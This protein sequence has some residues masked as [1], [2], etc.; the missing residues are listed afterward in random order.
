VCGADARKLGAVAVEADARLALEAL[1]PR[2]G[3]A[4]RAHRATAAEAAER[5]RAEI[6]SSG[7]GAFD[8]A[9]VYA[10][11]A[12][13]ARPGDWVVAAAG[14]APGDLLR[15]WTVPAGA[16][17]HLE[18]GFSCMGH[19]LPAALGIRMHEGAGGEVIVVVGDGSLLMAAAEL[20]TATQEGLKVTAVVVDNGGYGSI[21]ALARDAAGV[22]VGNRFTRRDGTELRTDYAGLATALGACGVR[23]DD[24]AS[25]AAALERAREGDVT[26]VIHCPVVAGDPP[27]AG[28]F[29]D[30]GVPAVPADGARRQVTARRLAL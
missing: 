12:E 17:A 22:S 25:L 5:W 26:T 19:E 18:F 2:T 1:R 29:W 7:S 24:A 15:L 27:S 21:D 30:L 16:H 8:R 10:A 23:A 4:P 13:A 11:V 20:L 28:A 14:W 6:D 3:R 9:A